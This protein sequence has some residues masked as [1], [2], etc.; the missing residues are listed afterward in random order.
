MRDIIG[1]I[2][3]PGSNG[4]HD[5][6]HALVDDVGVPARLVDY[7]ETDLSPYAALILPGGFSYGDYLRCGAI[8]RFAP[9]IEPLRDYAERGG[10]VLGICN[11]FQI[12]TEAHLLPGALLRN[13]TLRFHCHWTPLRIEQTDTLWTR[14]FI[15][16]E[17]IRLPVAHGD[18]SYYA[19]PE[20]LERLEATGRVVAR[21]CTP[22]GAITDEANPN[23]S[24]RAIAGIANERG[25]VVGLMPHPERATNELI[26]GN[27]GLRILR[28]V[29]AFLPVGA[30]R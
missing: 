21:Y 13:K 14:E 4:D 12:L 22:D 11:G 29:L 28:S 26:G 23:G 18:G 25:N 7:R 1:V 20:T 15:P 19:D 9:V 16:G 8:A 6:L 3:F 17:V 5:A 10:P 24:L 27:D 30:G 2:T